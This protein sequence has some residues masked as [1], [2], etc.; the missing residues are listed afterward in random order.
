MRCAKISDYIREKKKTPLMNRLRYIQ[1]GWSKRKG[2]YMKKCNIVKI[3]SD[4][5]S[6]IWAEELPDDFEPGDLSYNEILANIR[7]EYT[8]YQELLWELPFCEDM[9]KENRSYCK[10]VAIEY[11]LA[12][13]GECPFLR[14]AHDILKWDAKEKAEQVYSRWLEKN[15]KKREAN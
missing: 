6:K 3:A 10:K 4:L 9:W 13:I 2:K 11:R 8:N 12:S 5:V 14:E 1:K 7:H 15:K